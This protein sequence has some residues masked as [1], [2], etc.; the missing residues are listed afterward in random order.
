MRLPQG[1][2]PISTTLR[3]HDAVLRASRLL[4]G[5]N[6]TQVQTTGGVILSPKGTATGRRTPVYSNLNVWR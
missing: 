3:R 6:Q 1:N 5:P 2:G 4:A